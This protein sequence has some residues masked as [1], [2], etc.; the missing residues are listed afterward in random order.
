MLFLVLSPGPR[1]TESTPSRRG[2]GGDGAGRIEASS[3]NRAEEVGWRRVPSPD[4]LLGSGPPAEARGA[5]VSGRVVCAV[6]GQALRAVVDTGRERAVCMSD[7]SF[8]VWMHDASAAATVAAPGY[9]LTEI[10]CET[11]LASG[12]VALVPERLTTVVVVDELGRPITG[13]VVETVVS[14][15]EALR[16]ERSRALGA[17]DVDGRVSFVLGST[18]LIIARSAGRV[19]KEGL[20][21]P[22]VTSRLTVYDGGWIGLRDR[23]A[24]VGIS[25]ASIRV[26]RFHPQPTASFDRSTAQS[27]RIAHPLPFGQ[28]EIVDTG[29][30]FGSA[31]GEQDHGFFF[32]I[33]EADPEVWLEVSQNS[34]DRAL[35]LSSSTSTPITEV[36][37]WTASL[38]PGG[39]WRVRLKPQL[40]SVTAGRVD[41][42]NRWLEQIGAIRSRLYV[43]A[44]GHD[45]SFV[46]DPW[47]SILPGT[48]K[49][50]E[51][52]PSSSSTWIRILTSAGQPYRQPVRLLAW[53]SR[54]IVDEACPG[55]GGR[56]GP[57]DWMES[58]LVVTTT[59]TPGVELARVEANDLIQ[60]E[61]VLLTVD[62]SCTIDVRFPEEP[63]DAVPL[64]C[65]LANGASYAGRYVGDVLRFDQLIP[66]EYEVGSEELLWSF[67]LR[68]FHRRAYSPIRLET[69]D[70]VVLEWEP[71]ERVPERLTG[72]IK[73]AGIDTDRLFVAPVFEPRGVPLWG[74]RAHQ[75]VPVSKDG[76]FAITGLTTRPTQLMVGCM[77]WDGNELALGFCDDVEAPLLHVECGDLEIAVPKRLAGEQ[78]LLVHRPDFANR[79]V[80]PVFLR[81]PVDEHGVVRVRGLPVRTRELELFL[82][83]F[84]RVVE[85]R[86]EPG[87]TARVAVELP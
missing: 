2:S 13:A 60:T 38:G 49:R 27:G 18:K 8:R 57:I 73:A 64:G 40:R 85:V 43:K 26:V 15:S 7:G 42:P 4:D 63:V 21:E 86:L 17:T 31:A 46:E 45:L 33:G 3:E 83:G 39:D 51:L 69:G 6:T 24:G 68:R 22:G 55:V 14:E 16:G 67:S 76:F 59:G 84:K 36:S 66:G 65:R 32:V 75:R 54:F 78:A 81:E 23:E 71:E 25:D 1:S 37:L 35:L 9:E 70:H 48:A 11:I 29:G 74:G 61:E 30:A 34:A 41:L 52:K 50:L 56:V 79:P 62:A 82:A 5:Y 10:A 77:T 53:P 20:C 87:L 28:Y 80:Q 58:E 19:S 12:E 44:G 47:S 72:I